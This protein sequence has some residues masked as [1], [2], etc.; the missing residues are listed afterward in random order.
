MIVKGNQQRVIVV[1]RAQN[2]DGGQRYLDDPFEV[3]STD[4]LSK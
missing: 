2:T 1:L 3:S 4:D